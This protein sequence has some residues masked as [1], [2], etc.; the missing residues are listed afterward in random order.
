MIKN[1]NFRNQKKQHLKVYLNIHN[2]YKIKVYMNNV[3]F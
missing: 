2:A 1:N 3:F